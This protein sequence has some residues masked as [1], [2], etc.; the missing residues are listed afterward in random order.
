MSS[1][2][3]KIKIQA[4]HCLLGEVLDVGFSAQSNIFITSSLNIEKMSIM[5]Y[6]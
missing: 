5:K 6:C 1:G 4:G 3:E 2:N